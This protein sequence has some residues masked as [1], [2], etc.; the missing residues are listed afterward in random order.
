M[1]EP[2]AQRHGRQQ[3]ARLAMPTVARR[4]ESSGRGGAAPFA[5]WW[6]WWFDIVGAWVFVLR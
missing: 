1:N 4:E 2:A 5:G 6:W 3:M